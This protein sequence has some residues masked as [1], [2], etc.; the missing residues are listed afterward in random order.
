MRNRRVIFVVAV[1]LAVMAFV[2][3]RWLQTQQADEKAIHDL[4]ADLA[5]AADDIDEVVATTPPSPTPG[6]L[7]RMVGLL[8]RSDGLVRRMK[9]I[10]P[11]LTEE[12]S[13]DYR[14][15]RDRFL[16]SLQKLASRLQAKTSEAEKKNKTG[17]E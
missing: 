14:A 13:A 17:S 7:K 8:R 16:R 5:A 10:T 11:K 9:E 1:V 4:T 12:N 2:G 15:A 6:D 3:I